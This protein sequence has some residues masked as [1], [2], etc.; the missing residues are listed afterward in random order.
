MIKQTAGQV[1]SCRL[2][3]RFLGITPDKYIILSGL[4]PNENL[5]FHLLL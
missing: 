3:L 1:Q 4:N 5:T 2:F